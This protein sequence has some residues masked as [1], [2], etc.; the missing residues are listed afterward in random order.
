M[1]ASAGLDANALRV[2]N[3]VVQTLLVVVMAPG[4][5]TD[6]GDLVD[7]YKALTDTTAF[8]DAP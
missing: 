3:A 1:R 8:P 7:L 2:G 6:T 4:L 5:V